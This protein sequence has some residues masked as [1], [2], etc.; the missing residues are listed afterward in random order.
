MPM[1]NG[2]SILPQYPLRYTNGIKEAEEMSDR[3][4]SLTPEQLE[5]AQQKSLETKLQAEKVEDILHKSALCLVE[6]KKSLILALLESDVDVHII[7][8][9]TKTPIERVLELKE[10]MQ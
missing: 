10:S 4:Q 1:H 2:F 5:Q 7:S 9:S 8:Q 6:A 3:W